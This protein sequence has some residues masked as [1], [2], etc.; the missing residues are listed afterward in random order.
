MTTKIVEYVNAHWN[1]KCSKCGVDIQNHAFYEK[2]NETHTICPNDLIND[3][4]EQAKERLH[5]G[6]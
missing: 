4:K 5:K 3:L 2:D 1:E 6:E